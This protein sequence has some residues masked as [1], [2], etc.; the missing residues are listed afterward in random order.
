MRNRRH[1]WRHFAGFADSACHRF[2]HKLHKIT[3]SV[4][5]R[6][7]LARW[8]TIGKPSASVP[9]A[10]G[11]MQDKSG[12]KARP[13]C[14]RLRRRIATKGRLKPHAAC[15]WRNAGPVT[16]TQ[17]ECDDG[18]HRSRQGPTALQRHAG[19]RRA[20]RRLGRLGRSLAAMR[21]AWG[22]PITGESEAGLSLCGLCVA[23]STGRRALPVAGGAVL[24]AAH[25]GRHA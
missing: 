19:H 10:A 7:M 16:D 25:S 11:Q 4:P 6:A 15:P 1:A 9:A 23:A 14:P 22:A 8:Q 3:H 2:R 18:L 13:A 21:R 5:R 12:T 17:G 24:P 20:V